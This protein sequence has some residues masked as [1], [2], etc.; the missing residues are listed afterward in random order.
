MAWNASVAALQDPRQPREA[1]R[2]KAQR[3]YFDLGRDFL[4]RGI[5]NNP[6]RYT[7]YERLGTLQRDKYEDH[8]AAAEQ[9]AKAASFSNAPAYA[10]RFAAYELARCK[11]REQEAYEQ[12][13]ELY[14]RGEE[15]R[16]PTLLTLLA[17]LQEELNVP[18]AERVY[19]PPPQASP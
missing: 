11:G 3:E 5:R 13:R 8:C 18:P 7:L 2:I 12:L 6:D 17:Q 16:L 1:L 14:L 4:E 10:K 9:F 19:N 15:E